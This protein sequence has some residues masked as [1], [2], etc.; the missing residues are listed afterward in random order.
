MA[1]YDKVRFIVQ[2]GA[3]AAGTAAVT[4]KE[5]INASGSSSS[6]L[7]FTTY[8][9]VSGDTATKTTATSN[10]FNLATANRLYMVEFHANQLTPGKKFISIAIGNAGGADFYGVM[11]ECYGARYLQG[12]SSPTSLT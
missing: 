8:Y 3:W 10:T 9:V 6:T 1:L 2:T 7:A 5:A 11:A 4:F 12:A